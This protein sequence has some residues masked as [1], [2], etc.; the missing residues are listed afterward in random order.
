MKKYILSIDAGTSSSRAIIIDKNGEIN[1]ISQ[2]EF[3]QYYP[4]N[5]WVEHNPLEIWNISTKSNKRCSN[6]KSNISAK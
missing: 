2:Y 1:G 5:G 3:K 4:K 6:S